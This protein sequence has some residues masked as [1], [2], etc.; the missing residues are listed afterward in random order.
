MRHIQNIR[1]R[2]NP[3]IRTRRRATR[4]IRR[5]RRITRRHI[6]LIAILARRSQD[7]DTQDTNEES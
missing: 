7:G 3:I 6:I 4:A 2:Q 5:L 1:G